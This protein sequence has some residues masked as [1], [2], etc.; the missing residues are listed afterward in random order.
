MANRSFKI[1]LTLVFFLT[2]FISFGADIYLQKDNALWSDP[3][4]WSGGVLPTSSDNV[5]LK[6]EDGTEFDK[7]TIDSVA[8][9]LSM[10]ASNIKEIDVKYNL[11]RSIE[12]PN[13]IVNFYNGSNQIASSNFK[14]KA[15]EIYFKEGTV[16]IIRYPYF[17]ADK[18]VVEENASIY[19]SIT[20]LGYYNS[21]EIKG[22]LIHNGKFFGVRDFDINLDGSFINNGEME[23]VHHFYI[24]K[25]IENNSVL[26]D[27]F[28]FRYK[29]STSKNHPVEIKGSEKVSLIVTN[30]SNNIFYFHDSVDL[31]NFYS[32]YDSSVIDTE[33]SLS[34][35][36]EDGKSFK[37]EKVYGHNVYFLNNNNFHL[38]SYGSITFS[39]YRLP[40]IYAEKSTVIIEGDGIFKEIK[41][42]EI[43]FLEGIHEYPYKG[44]T[45]TAD[46]IVLEEGSYIRNNQDPYQSGVEPLT[47]NGDVKNMGSLGDDNFIINGNLENNGNVTNFKTIKVYGDVYNNGTFQENSRGDSPT[48]FAYGDFYN[49]GTYTSRNFYSYGNID[50]S[51][52][53]E[54][55]INLYENV[56]GIHKK[57]SFSGDYLNSN[58]IIRENIT[59]DK[60]V[61][62]IPFDIEDAEIIVNSNFLE[63]PT[64]KNSK[65][66]GDFV[67]EVRNI[68]DTEALNVK[69]SVSNDIGGNISVKNIVLTSGDLENG[70]NR[71]SD[72]VV[73]FETLEIEENVS[74]EVYKRAPKLYGKILNKGTI[75]GLDNYQEL[76]F[77]FEDFNNQG[78]IE[79]EISVY[80]YFNKEINQTN[81][82]FIKE[83][84]SFS[85]PSVDEIKTGYSARVEDYLNQTDKEFSIWYKL[86][87]ESEWKVNYFNVDFEIPEIVVPPPE[88]ETLEFSFSNIEDHL[89]N[90]EVEITLSAARNLQDRD[91][92]VRR[93]EMYFYLSTN[94][95]DIVYPSVV[96]FA[97]DG[98][99]Y[100]KEKTFS[101][102]IDE[103]ESDIE[104]YIKDSEGNLLGT[105][106]PFSVVESGKAYFKFREDHY[107]RYDLDIKLGTKDYSFESTKSINLMVLPCDENLSVIPK[108]NIFIPSDT[109]LIH[110][111]FFYLPIQ[112]NI[113]CDTTDTI[114]IAKSIPYEN[115][116]CEDSD[117]TPVLLLPGIMGSDTKFNL[118][119]YPQIPKDSPAW[120][121][122][123]LV[124]H[125][126]GP[127]NFSV[128][129]E[130]LKDELRSEGYR[131][132][133]NIIDVPYDWRLEIPEIRDLYLIPWIE[134]AKRLTGKDEVDIVAHS[135]GGLVARSFIQSSKHLN[136]V[137][138]FVMVGT[139]NSGSASTYPIWEG[140]D[141][142]L[143][144][145]NTQDLSTIGGYVSKYFYTNTIN[146]NYK[147]V[148]EDKDLCIWESGFLPAPIY[149]NKEKVY[150]FLHT[151]SPSVGNLMP[152]YPGALKDHLSEADLNISA[153]PNNFL[154]A[155][156]SG[157][158]YGRDTYIHPDDINNKISGE[159]I[160][161]YGDNFDTIENIK[162]DQSFSHQFLYQDGK[163]S[164]LDF[165]IKN[166][167][168]K[169]V[170]KVSIPIGNINLSSDVSD[171]EHGRLINDLKEEIV[172]FI[173]NN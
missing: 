67:L 41:A 141:P 25:N 72:D 6:K 36:L 96:T 64:L 69:V 82:Y 150:D 123:K 19:I 131:G 137:R 170:P 111:E 117:K 121:S 81:Q 125:D 116:V 15:K 124:L 52:I 50:S 86:P 104:I 91:S 94:K 13:S 169:T 34:I 151:Y 60:S 119:V 44:N 59:L 16:E 14:I 23:D 145:K 73:R 68:I 26:P 161:F 4:A 56:D 85:E 95:G 143:V 57:L 84:T 173:N 138:N 132:G 5:Y 148:I 62:E 147:K 89:K 134:E 152:T 129:W 80:F 159:S 144:D 35:Y 126:P 65:L 162:V 83:G 39:P 17:E 8:T 74:L 46:N 136:E 71:V 29:T 37:A 128:G 115:W 33:N 11:Y 1:F 165:I 153:E 54:T 118:S 127:A 22:D 24:S 122:E 78:I 87:E 75:Y 63:V 9:Y 20:A 133:C 98:D 58:L 130:N 114:E 79:N 42:K 99:Y 28:Y 110:Q 31:K 158:D 109:G 49:F 90:E 163:P 108:G 172:E 155:L 40:N 47:I 2:P 120:D 97:E 10:D 167:G 45:I 51:D 100:E 107:H 160:L 171:Q 112:V 38:E 32:Y 43:Y 88:P 142:I 21:I 61:R 168:D 7:I 66:E 18:I 140:G 106:K 12:A 113:S 93:K 55:S 27:D 156:N 77:I 92:K 53:L 157:G 103:A 30:D 149:C 146:K 70:V 76:L 101:M 154:L 105:S 164:G 139:P 48:I 135:M 3:T 166:Q 102:K